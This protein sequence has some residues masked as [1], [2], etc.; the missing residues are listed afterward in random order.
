[1]R[2][3]ESGRIKMEEIAGM[4]VIVAAHGQG[5]LQV[6]GAVEAV[7]SRAVSGPLFSGL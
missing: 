7:T 1:M 5:G 2:I 6:A 3:Y 4:R